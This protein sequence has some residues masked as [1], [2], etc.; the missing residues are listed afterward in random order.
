[1]HE[2]VNSEIHLAPEKMKKLKCN[3]ITKFALPSALISKDP[4]PK[5]PSGTADRIPIGGCL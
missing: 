1:M 5:A 3:T 2:R 4:V